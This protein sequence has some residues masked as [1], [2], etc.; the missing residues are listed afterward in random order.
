MPHSNG[1]Q[2]A[3][4]SPAATPMRVWPSMIRA[5]RVAIEMSASSAAASPAPT[6]GPWIA[7]TIG[8]EQLITL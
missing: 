3:A 1:Q 5:D 4:W 2:I 6:A 7:D 8:F